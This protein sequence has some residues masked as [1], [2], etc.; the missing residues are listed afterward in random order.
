MCLGAVSSRTAKVFEEGLLLLTISITLFSFLFLYF[1]PISESF[2]V[3][4]VSKL[5]NVHHTDFI[6]KVVFGIWDFLGFAP[7]DLELSIY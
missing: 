3:A 6:K 2:L 5:E 4:M 1:F 7:R